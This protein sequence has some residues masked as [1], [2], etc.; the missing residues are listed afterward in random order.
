[1]EQ[2]TRMS[3]QLWARYKVEEMWECEWKTIKATLPNKK[4]IEAAAKAQNINTRDA[5]FGGRTEGFK[6][7]HEC[8]GKQVINY[9]DVTS[10]Y[11]TVNALDDNAIGFKKYVNITPKD[12]KSGKFFGIA[13]VDITPP[14][15]LYVPVLPQSF[16]KKLL[17]RLEEMEGGTLSSV[18]LQRALQNGYVITKIHA[19]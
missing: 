8:V 5:L 9:D 16:N 13:K 3:T 17:F 14:D 18:E 2:S 12:I 11:P 7:Y 4:E 10:L 1:M 15:D 19:A 6:S